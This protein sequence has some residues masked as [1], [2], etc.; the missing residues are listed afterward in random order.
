MEGRSKLQGFSTSGGVTHFSHERPRNS[1]LGKVA[2][3]L[4]VLGL[5]RCLVTLVVWVQGC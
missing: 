3:T 5:A 4:L 2:G 1:F